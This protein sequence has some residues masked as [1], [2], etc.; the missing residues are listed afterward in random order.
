MR[1]Q[2]FLQGRFDLYSLANL[3]PP[4]PYSAII[5]RGWGTIG[6]N[7]SYPLIKQAAGTTYLLEPLVQVA[8]SPDTNIYPLIP[9]QDSEIWQFDETNLFQ[10]NKS[11]GYD[12]Y[13]AGQSVT[14]GGRATVM[15]PGGRS[16]SLLLGRVFQFENDPA[17]PQRTGL[18]SALS[19]YVVSGEA[20]PFQNVALFTRLRL[21]SHDMAVNYLE[22]GANFATSRVS[23][24][25]AYLYE[26]RLALGRP[27][28]Q[29]RHPRRGR[30]H[31]A[32]G[33]DG[34]HHCR[35]R[36]L[37]PDGVWGGLQGPLRAG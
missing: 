4:D 14:L 20:K 10:T 23:G 30:C 19:D 32:L 25:I 27:V 22:S 35:R 18:Q 12:L 33:R 24:Y 2:P 21:D 8:I 28:E 17:V 7:V 3:T 15:L 34:L 11:P 5:G 6:L 29:P 13:E 36:N 31:Q 1:L 9:N 16:G 37:A 26:T